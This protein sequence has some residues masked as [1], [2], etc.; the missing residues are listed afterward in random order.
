MRLLAELLGSHEDYSL[1]RSLEA[2]KRVSDTNPNFERTLKNNAECGYCRS[3]IYENAEYLYVPELE[4]LLGELRKAV[5]N[6]EELDREAVDRGFERIKERYFATP[7][8]EM[9]E[10][11][12]CRTFSE[13]TAEAAKAVADMNL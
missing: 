1:Y 10:K 5:R 3:F 8:A 2:L 6:G 12:H 7:L 11:K 9:D 13:V 4:L